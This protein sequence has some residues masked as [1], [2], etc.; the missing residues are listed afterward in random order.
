MRVMTVEKNFLH[1]IN[2]PPLDSLQLRQQ[3]PSSGYVMDWKIFASFLEVLTWRSFPVI[4]TVSFLLWCVREMFVLH[5]RTEVF[6]V[7]SSLGVKFRLL[8]VLSDTVS[9]ESV[10]HPFAIIQTARKT[11]VS[12]HCLLLFYGICN[13]SKDFIGSTTSTKQPMKVTM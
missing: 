8:Q 11:G 12:S 6:E 7:S 9:S 3:D 10:W 13:S 1:T 5:P 2:S 4:F